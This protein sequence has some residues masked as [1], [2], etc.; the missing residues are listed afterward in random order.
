MR[1]EWLSENM[2]EIKDFVLYSELSFMLSLYERINRLEVKSCFDIAQEM[3][4]TLLKNNVFLLECGFC[5]QREHDI[6]KLMR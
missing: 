2:P 4:E 6:L 1:T 3:K 5:T